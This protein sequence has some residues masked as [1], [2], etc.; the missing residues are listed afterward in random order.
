[1]KVHFNS[2]ND[3]DNAPL[4]IYAEFYIITSHM[5]MYIITCKNEIVKRKLDTVKN[6]KERISK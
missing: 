5:S 4:Y 3:G 1:L 2:L 6:F